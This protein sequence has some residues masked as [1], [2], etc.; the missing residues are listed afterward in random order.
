VLDAKICK[1]K[2]D[3]QGFLNKVLL[4]EINCSCD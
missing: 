4:G 2:G 3:V 1:R